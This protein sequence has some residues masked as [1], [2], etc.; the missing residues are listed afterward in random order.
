M[1]QKEKWNTFY[2]L[3]KREP[4]IH[5]TEEQLNDILKKFPDAQSALDIGC[6]EGQLLVQLEK[7]G[8]FSTGIDVSEVGLDEA[9]KQFKGALILGDFEEFNFP[10]ESSFD[11]IFVKFVVAFIKNPA[12]F[13]KKVDSLL[14]RGGG[15]ILLT[16]V[17]PKPNIQ[18]QE[19]EVFVGQA[20]IDTYLPQYFSK[21][22]EVV[23]YSDGSK[24]LVLYICKKDK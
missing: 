19:E 13:F 9:K 17:M 8:L 4:F 21:I 16:P 3:K 24:R 10:E 23:L 18:L 11:L 7:R 6:G 5:F 1:N 20:V 12:D 2:S 22:D 15:F 14:K